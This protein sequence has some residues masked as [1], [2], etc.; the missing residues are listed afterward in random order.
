[1]P[2]LG[3]YRVHPSHSG[4]RWILQKWSTAVGLIAALHGG[5]EGW[6]Y[7]GHTFPDKKSAETFLSK[8]GKT[9]PMSSHTTHH[10][11]YWAQCPECKQL[12][13]DIYQYPKH[14][15]KP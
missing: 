15:F 10:F 13:Q 6:Q 1:M 12:F 2:K 11:Q 5:G 9:C 3:D 14:I 8:I 7:A 4:R